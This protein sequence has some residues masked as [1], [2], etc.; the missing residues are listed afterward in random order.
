MNTNNWAEHLAHWKTFLSE[1][2]AATGDEGERIKAERQLRTIERVRCAAVLNPK[3]LTEFIAPPDTLLS[4]P[5]PV[6]HPDY[7][8]NLN[9][10]Q[11]KAVETAL[12]DHVLSLIQGPPGTGKTQVIAEICLQLYRQDPAVRILVC[13]ETHI[14]VNNLISRISEYNDRI[15]IVRIRDKE[16]NS[17]ADEFSPE[18][19]VHTYCEWLQDFCKDPDIACSISQTLSDCEDKS[20]EKA[21]A[22]SANITGMTCNRVS[23]YEFETSSEMFDIVIIDEVC[24]ATLPEILAPL[25][26]ARKAVLVGDPKQL[27]PVFCSEELEII[28]S[29]EQCDLQSYLYIDELFSRS[30][31]VTILDTQYRMTD[32]IG[33]LIGALFYGGA[34]KN[35]RNASDKGCITWIDYTPTKAWPLQGKNNAGNPRIFNLDEGEIIRSL[36]WKLADSGA[37]T[38]A[39]VI[40]PYRQQAASIRKSLRPESFAGLDVNVDTVDGFQGKESDIVIF[41]LTRTHGSFRFLADARRLNV[42]LSRARDRLYI[43][44]SL[45]YAAHHELLRSIAQY[46]R[47]A[48]WDEPLPA[49]P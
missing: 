6:R 7:F 33:S 34:L 25:T 48:V 12:G 16:P 38:S 22:L 32:Q 31:R 11:Q 26:V 41:S 43:V 40:T 45:R 17:A 47:K 42:A 18:T 2:L 8:L 4:E 15:R 3:V 27:P 36:L 37:G 14:A 21:L 19:I 20:L 30:P 29:I 9:D 28:R 46:C 39:A 1:R 24:K 13:S 35:G 49:A 44:G 23:A 10:S 5:E